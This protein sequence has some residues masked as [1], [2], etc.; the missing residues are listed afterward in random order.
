MME[1]LAPAGNMACLTAAVSSGA[2]AV[3]FAG[4]NF[5]ARSYADN[6]SEAEIA[7]AAKYCRFR[8]VKT[9]VTVNTTV[10]DREFA[11]LDEY[12]GVLADAGVD[13][14]IVQDLGVANRFMRIC[15]DI[16]VHASTQMTIHNTD[17]VRTLEDMG[18][19]RAVLAR[20]LSEH[21][22]RTIAQNTNAELEVFVHGAMCMSYSGQCL[23][24]SVL[25]GR[26]GNRGMCAQPCRLTYGATQGAEKHTYLSLKDMSLIDHLDTLRKIGVASL[27]IEGRMKG[28]EYVSKVVSVFRACI[29][30]GGKPTAE[31]K[32]KLN[33]VFYRGGLTDG[34]FTG[35]IGPK[36]FEFDKPEN[37]YA[38][39]VKT[40]KTDKTACRC[41]R[42]SCRGVFCA[43]QK[44]ITELCGMGI[45]ITVSGNE[46]L[47]EAEKKPTEAD[48]IRK[49]LSKTGGTPFLFDPIELEIDGQPYVPLK[50]INDL[51]RRA[52]A[53][54]EAAV[55]ETARKKVV[56]LPPID[57]RGSEYKGF[58][59]TA[60]V[61]DMEQ[62]RAL[63]GYPFEY[64]DLPI[65][66]I[67]ENSSELLS[68][69]ARI[70]INPGA[71][72]SERTA[73]MRVKRLDKLKKLGFD[74]L[75]AENISFLRYAANFKLFGGFRLNITNTSA[76][77]ALGKYGL[78]SVCLSPELNLAQIGGIKKRIAA[79]AIIYG[80]IP[81]MITENCVLKNMKKC[82]C[83]GTGFIYDRKNTAFP[84][85]KDDCC[86]SIILNSV[87]VYMGDKLPEVKAAGI[88]RGLI[89]FFTEDG[90][91]VR[92]VC[93]SYFNSKEYT[94]EYTRLHFYK[95]VLKR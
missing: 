39:S 17:G 61:S 35:G 78:E 40:E 57:T 91:T 85:V 90:E 3:Y 34:Y 6:F 32:D 8:G 28:P 87:P 37:P 95:G 62:Y 52:I 82:P 45:K 55:I 70:V 19:S 44:P 1:L 60:S 80:H 69:L 49:Q 13:G 67:C 89:L 25:G 5:G 7:E 77:D 94:G 30:R 11:E 93:S 20:E 71:I 27:K 74:K 43:G 23:M 64:I 68:D 73:G 18:I 4:K 2:D 15:P 22:I 76:M 56:A 14:V 58:G 21:D 47:E 75:R 26:S 10:L 59:F 54:F 72:A 84:V 9:Y 92:S 66:V 38:R 36:M 16:K 83:G 65:D 79:E 63:C 50:L 51:R 46:A 42:L 86:R 12:I 81:L 53:D 48:N 41:T 24:S 31:E 88:N 29:D 33:R